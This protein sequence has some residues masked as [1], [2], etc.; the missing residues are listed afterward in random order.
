MSYV[1][2]LVVGV[3]GL[4]WIGRGRELFLLSARDGRVLLVRGRIP[5]GLMRDMREILSAARVHRATVRAVRSDG[6]ARLEISGVEEG[7]AQRLRNAFGLY[8][9]SRLSTAPSAA[10]PSLGQILGI[11]WLAWLFERSSR[12]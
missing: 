8:P 10:N 9:I 5:A 6:G 12:S 4:W 3:I 2:L 11:V 1:V 7:P